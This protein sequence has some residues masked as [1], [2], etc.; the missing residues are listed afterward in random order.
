MKYFLL[1]FFSVTTTLFGQVAVTENDPSSL[2][3]GL[4][5]AITGD[6]FSF[7]EDVVVQGVEPLHLKRTYISSK[8]E[9]T[10]RLFPGNEAVLFTTGVLKLIE[11]NGTVLRYH[12][13]RRIEPHKKKKNPQEVIFLPLDL[14]TDAKG[15]TNTARGA[16]SANNN[17]KNQYVRESSI[18]KELIVYCPN[19]TRRVY[20]ALTKEQKKARDVDDSQVVFILVSEGLPDGNQII[21]SWDNEKITSIRTADPSGQKTYAQATFHF[22]GSLKEKKGHKYLDTRNLDVHT[23]DGRILQYR[24]LCD[25]PKESGGWYLHHIDSSDLPPEEMRYQNIEGGRRLLSEIFLPNS[26]RLNVSYYNLG[27]NDN[28]AKI[29]EMSDPLYCR[30]KALSAPVGTDANSLPTRRFYYDIPSRKTQ[31]FDAEGVPTHYYWDEN[32]RLTSI[33][34]FST[35]EKLYNST[36]FVW[37]SNNA[38]DASN[39]LCK[40]L[41]DENRRPMHATRYF[42]DQHGNVVQEKFYGNLSGQGIS[43]SLD[44]NNFPIENGVEAYSKRFEYSQDGRNLLTRR[45]ED[46]GSDIRYEYLPGTNLPTLE[47]SYERGKVRRRKFYEYNA[48]RILIRELTDDGSTPDKND[49]SDVK[50]RLIQCIYPKSDQ[51]YFGM[52]QIL[53]EKYWDG[54]TEK[55]LKKTVL[56]YTTGGRISQKDIYDANDQLR[57][58]LTYKYDE[59]GRLKEE[60]NALNQ[61]SKSAYDEV[62]NKTFSQS[63]GGRSFLQM[64]YDYSNRLIESKEEG[65]D[66]LIRI[67]HHAYDKRN[68]KILTRDP[69]GYETR[70]VYDA[71][72]NLKETH[73]EAV[74]ELR[75]VISSIYDAAG[76]EISHTDAQGYTT[77]TTY[78]A[79]SKPMR[80]QHPDGTEEQFIYNL[81]G[82]IHKQIDQN[83]TQ[84]TYA[85]DVF[86]RI[87]SKIISSQEEICSQETFAYDAY[88]LIAQTNAEGSTTFYA[89]DGAG[90]IIFEEQ[91]QECVD[92]A[93]DS[94]GRLNVVQRE[95]LL[96]ITEYDFLDNILEERKEDAYGNILSRVTYTYDEA[97]N[98]KSTT[99]FVH[100]KE[101][102]EILK[103]DSFNRLIENKDPLGNSTSF[104]HNDQLH[105]LTT[106]DPLGLQFIERFNSHYLRS[107]FEKRNSRNERL[108]REESFYD[109]NDN[110]FRKESALFNPNRT[111]TTLW[112]YGPLNRL[113]ML[114]EAA[115]TSEQ[116]ITEY[117]YTPKGLLFQT[118]KPSGIT[119][120][121][122]YDP[123]D[124]LRS[125]KS[126]D[127]TINYTYIHNRLGHLLQSRDEREKTT[128]KRTYDPK[129]RLLS[130]TLSNHLNLDLSIQN[131]YDKQGRRTRLDLPD[132]SFVTY[133]FDPLY[134]RA[135]ARRDSNGNAQ[136]TH[137]YSSYDLA[138]NPLSQE[139]IGNLGQLYR[140]YDAAGRPI[141]YNS[142]YFSHEILRYDEVGNILKSRLHNETLDYAYDDLYQLVSEKD[143]TYGYD[144][145]YNRF[146]KD[147]STYAV[148]C[149]NQLPTEFTYNPDGNPSS[150]AKA[151]YT[152]DALDRLISIENIT[153]RL[154][155]T[156]DS[157]HRRLSKTVYI[158]ENGLWKP[159]QTVFYLY[160]DQNEIGAV[161]ARGKL[162]ELRILGK[163][164]QAEIGAA[165]ALELHGQTYAPLHDIHGN[166]AMLVSVSDQTCEQYRYTAFGEAK[167]PIPLSR[168]PWRFSSKRL[169]E[170]TNLVYFGR[171]YYLSDY[172]R[173]LTPDPLGLDAG[174]NMYA[175]VSNS[176]LTHVDLYGLLGSRQYSTFTTNDFKQ[177]GIG[178]AHG[179]GDFALNTA[180]FLSTAGWGLTVPFRSVN[181]M[182]GRSTFSQDW[183]SIQRSNAALHASGKRWMQSALPG[184]MNHR[185]YGLFRHGTNDG[186]GLGTLAVG[187]YAAVVKG[188]SFFAQKG[189]SAARGMMDLR[190]ISKPAIQ[191]LQLNRFHQAARNLSET[192][193]NNIRILRGWAKSKGWEKFPNSPGA[194]ETWGNFNSFNKFDWRLKI[195][196]EASFREGLHVN[197]NVPRASARFEKEL[198]INP[199]T[200]ETGGV[201][202][203]GHIPLENLYYK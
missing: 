32:L 80:I 97:G 79:Y 117:A 195:K 155:F 182:S 59:K 123:L 16:L 177:A 3:D 67:T 55:L 132:N 127:E 178:T 167:H 200:G 49:L 13:N 193:Q 112:S 28:G 4:V 39:L 144:S 69:H 162:Q 174:P 30:V 42:Y 141:S 196:P 95:N 171:R 180:S 91:N 101:S 199:F 149:L 150:H 99:R 41:L 58:S 110:L 152:Y 1:L 92:Y 70:Y 37:G 119:L 52:P 68:N 43:L 121:I 159:T 96:S 173:W 122:T 198:Y 27:K 111:I 56:H 94:L 120:T 90:R 7:E 35:P 22:H 190:K 186:I 108:Y 142:R 146:Q 166:V 157:Y 60:T 105:Q 192:G 31:V 34:R 85:Y 131:G 136:Y 87:L 18:G 126:S 47:L 194:P 61:I 82:T 188:A 160:D 14:T 113:S 93:Y 163:T 73:P 107:T 106:I 26:R 2:V 83:G 71:L 116:K 176:P 100:G 185:G 88:H 139:M 156:Y 140:T 130:E 63:F 147:A 38:T 191:E 184:D 135:V 72:G 50:T 181:W 169:D 15:L 203:G 179:I 44:S 62:G 124:H 51:P 138:G 8:G 78:N 104:I 66:S 148:N 109:A 6:L 161:D 158:F 137:I 57:F 115:G 165:V 114:T 64:K 17:L 24:Y 81:D 5:S 118:T 86:G 75:S 98:R 129:G 36:R 154:K 19:G 48:D 134:L 202:V 40:I 151:H 77:L 170:E 45:S 125:Q 153:Q 201:N 187:A 168:N 21:Y 46:N 183:E 197:S 76:C 189:F 175:F 143:H 53:E 133:S 12:S 102:T 10:W 54:L 128:L 33:D 74:G 11:P 145:L 103:Y 29:R 84:T 23:S 25:G 65:D 9:K 89:Y 172:G 20:N 164:P